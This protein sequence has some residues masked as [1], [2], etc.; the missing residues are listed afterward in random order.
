MSL[1]SQESLNSKR[2]GRF[3]LLALLGLAILLMGFNYSVYTK[4]DTLKNGV[5]LKLALAPRDPRALMTGDYMALNT[6]LATKIR[7]DVSERTFERNDGFVI[8]KPDEQGVSRFVRIQ[9]NNDGLATNE[10]ALKY[11]DRSSGVRVGT[12]AFSFQ[13]GQAQAFESA[14][15]GEYRLATNGDLLLVRMLDEKLAPI[16]AIGRPP[17]QLTPQ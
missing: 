3:E 16:V 12:D 2:V 1:T 11:R 13:E 10:F 6:E 9:S 15:F 7:R 17:H 8:V 4:E 14:R 5:A